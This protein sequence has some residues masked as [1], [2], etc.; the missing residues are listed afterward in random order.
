MFW[1]SWFVFVFSLTRGTVRGGDSRE[2]D[3]S[4]DVVETE[5]LEACGEVGVDA[6][7]AEELVV[8]YVVAFERDR[9]GDADGEV[10]KNGE[11]AVG[12]DAGKRE[13]VGYFVDCEEE[14]VVRGSSHDVRA[15]NKDG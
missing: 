1:G 11:E 6:V 3:F 12:D 2:K 9:V 7:L 13:V 14:I 15:E 4:E 10:G 8:L 5:K